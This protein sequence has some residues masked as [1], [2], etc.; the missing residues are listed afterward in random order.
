MSTVA[1]AMMG[2]SSSPRVGAVFATGCGGR[3]TF[4]LTRLMDGDFA[5]FCSPPLWPVLREAQRQKRT[6]YYADHGYYGR[7]Q[8]YRVTRNA[9]QHT[10]NGTSN[11]R[12]FKA[13]GL[14]VQPWRDSGRHIVVC[15]NSEIY[16]RLHGFDV[17]D[18]LWRVTTV[19]Q[20][21]TDREIRVRWKTDERTRPLTHDLVDA[22]AVVV[23]SSAAALRALIAGVPVF[24]LAQFAASARMGISDLAQI[25]SPVY[26]DDRES[27]L[28]VLADQQWTLD[29]IKSGLAWRALQASEV[30]RA[31]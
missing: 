31:A 22:H 18:W 9:Y 21:H 26:P 16:C 27:F 23:F 2:E 13:F 6:W 7:G 12:R 10:G 29:E 15:P 20:T 1:Y 11:G 4:D 25:E 5:A 28:S 8:F 24:T 3:L 19:L 14:P 30:E 17:N